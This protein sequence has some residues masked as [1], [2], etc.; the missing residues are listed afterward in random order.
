VEVID[1]DME[2]PKPKGEVPAHGDL[3]KDGQQQAN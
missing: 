1:L 2:E 3:K